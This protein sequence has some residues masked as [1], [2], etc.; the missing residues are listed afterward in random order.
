MLRYLVVAGILLATTAAF[1]CPAD[2][3]LRLASNH[4][5]KDLEAECHRSKSSIA[6][7]KQEDVNKSWK[8][9][10]EVQN[11]Y[12]KLVAEC[13]AVRKSGKTKRSTSVTSDAGHAHRHRH[14]KKRAID[15]VPYSEPERQ[16]ISRTRRQVCMTKSKETLDK[17]QQ[18]FKDHCDRENICLPDEDLPAGAQQDRIKQ[19]QNDRAKKYTTYLSLVSM[20]NA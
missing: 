12:K 9:F 13:V 11:E 20:C 6:C 3:I 15:I 10:E 14:H 1:E 16:Q 2:T 17:M 18:N 7:E 8:A 19:V 5:S 4:R